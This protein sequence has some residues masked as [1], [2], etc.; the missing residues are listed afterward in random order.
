MRTF[1]L[2]AIHLGLGALIS[3]SALAVSGTAAAAPLPAGWSCTG[4]CGTMA[5]NGDIVASPEGGDYG[6]VSTSGGVSDDGLSIGSETNGSRARSS[7]FTAAA[8]DDL[9]FN[10]N[11][12]TSD[13]QIYVE[14]AWVK[15]LNADLSDKAVLFTARTTTAGNTVPGNGLPAL[16]PGV[17][18]DP[19]ATPIIA[20][21]PDWSALGGSSGT[22]F[23]AGCGYT[24]WVEMT[25]EIA[26]AGDY[27]LEF[28][29]VNWLDE[30]YQT[31]LAFDGILVAGKPIDPENPIPEPATLALLGLGLLGLGSMRRRKAA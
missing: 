7:K 28:G 15:L 11:Y 17:V 25:Y 16:A 23:G 18:L 6:Y 31:G 30:A 9:E 10:F 1:K 13:G 2:S 20:G 26:D 4:N 29:V 27:F 22:C 12:V 8:G 3:L 24:G 5:P 19:A 14:Y 21:A